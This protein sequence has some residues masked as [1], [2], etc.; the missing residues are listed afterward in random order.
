LRRRR[1]FGNMRPLYRH[2]PPG[3][4]QAMRM[5]RHTGSPGDGRSPQGAASNGGAGSPGDGRSPQGAA[6]NARQ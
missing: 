5:G 1:L 2:A 6:S 3:C 4:S